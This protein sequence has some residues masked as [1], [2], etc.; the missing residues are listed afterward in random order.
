MCTPD[1]DDVLLYEVNGPEM[2]TFSAGSP[3]HEQ[4]TTDYR[5][6]TPEVWG[7]NSVDFLEAHGLEFSPNGVLSAPGGVFGPPDNQEVVVF[8]E[9]E[10]GEDLKSTVAAIK[11]VT[12]NCRRSFNGRAQR[13][14]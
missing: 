3:V 12:H 10:I 14:L 7:M 8:V 6:G 2:Y 11:V 4:F 5:I 13:R 9:Q 1:A